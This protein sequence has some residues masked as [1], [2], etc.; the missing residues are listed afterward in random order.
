MEH[1]AQPIAKAAAANMSDTNLYLCNHRR[2]TP[3]RGSVVI[4]TGYIKKSYLE[5][6]YGKNT[7]NRQAQ[8]ILSASVELG[9]R[10]IKIMGGWWN[11]ASKPTYSVLMLG[12]R[13]PQKDGFD[14]GF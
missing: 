1:R 7:F 5:T 6:E 3:S 9:A 4:G 13:N 14:A 10:H 2:I 8:K 12:R 11:N